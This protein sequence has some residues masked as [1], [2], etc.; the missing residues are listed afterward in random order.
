MLEKRCVLHGLRDQIGIFCNQPMGQ[1]LS[2][3]R[4]LIFTEGSKSWTPA[5]TNV[6]RKPS[7]KT[8]KTKKGEDSV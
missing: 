6:S 3:G 4:A 5:D 1:T 7:P 2:C 8:S